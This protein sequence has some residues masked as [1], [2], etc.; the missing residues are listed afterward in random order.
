MRY[1]SVTRAESISAVWEMRPG[2]PPI[3]MTASS[4]AFWYWGDGVIIYPAHGA[5]SVCGSRIADRDES[6]LG[7]EKLQN[8]ALQYADK[9]SFVRAKVAEI[10]EKPPYFTMME[11]LNLEGPPL[12]KG[13][14]LPRPLTP[15]EFK[16][17]MEKGALVVDTSL[18]AAFGGAHIQGTYNIWLGG[19]PG[20]AG[21]FLPYGKPILLV[22]QDD[23]Q[24]GEAVRYLIRL[25]YDNITGYLKG[26]IEAWYDYSY[27][28][29]KLDLI[30]VHEL[31]AKI[32]KRESFTL[33]DV[34]AQ[35]EWETG[36]I[37]GAKHLYIGHVEQKI[38]E[39]PADKPVVLICT[40]GRR[41][42][43]AAS[44][45]LKAGYTRVANVLGSM[46][47]WRQAGYPTVSEAKKAL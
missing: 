29:E 34:R 9:D 16:S 6:T 38:S 2:Q 3:Y 7:L 26:G 37:A 36:H 21:W 46:A 10:H 8:P 11:K 47:A 12:L 42:S 18:P 13:L 15:A 4:T 22:L 39:I 17:A 45:L 35:D 41:A 44:L 27:P 23:S 28:V 33:L 30:T 32:D 1:S 14:P 25:G 31:K 5:G 24:I 20:F 40:V 19:L 43:I